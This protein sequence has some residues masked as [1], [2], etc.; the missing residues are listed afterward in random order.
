MNGPPA[1]SAN[2]R[3][4]S[5]ELTLSFS[6]TEM[7][8]KTPNLILGYFGKSD[9]NTSPQTERTAQKG[10]TTLFSVHSR[11]QRAAVDLPDSRGTKTAN[12][13]IMK[14]VR[15]ETAFAIGTSRR[16]YRHA[17]GQANSLPRSA[18]TISRFKI[19]AL[20]DRTR[21]AKDTRFRT[22]GNTAHAGVGFF[23]RSRSRNGP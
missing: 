1:T 18:E 6:L 12:Y 23:G 17:T 21:L 13:V 7:P 2:R 4:V 22:V 9:A 8:S 11:R 20:P 5:G 15:C 16:G 10:E 19:G 3:P 14:V